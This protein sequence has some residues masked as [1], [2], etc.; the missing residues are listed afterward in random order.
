MNA[1]LVNTVAPIKCEVTTIRQPERQLC[2]WLGLATGAALVCSSLEI[3]LLEQLDSLSKYMTFREIAWDSA[4]AL[5]VLLGVTLLWWLFGL[6]LVV[7]ANVNSRK[8][9]DFY[10][11]FWHFA[12]ILPLS[13]F[14]LDLF[15]A[16]RLEFFPH[17]FPELTGWITLSL[18]FLVLA[19]VCIYTIDVPKIQRFC[20]HYVAPIGYMHFG[21]AAI[22]TVGLLGHNIHLYRDYIHSGRTVSAAN[23]PDVYLVTVDALRAED[24]SLYGYDRSTT[25]NLDRFAQRSFTFDAFFANSNFTTPA[26]TSIETGKLPWSHRVFHLGGFLRGEAQKENLAELLH[27]QG[28]Y[29]ATIS[30]NYLATPLLHRTLPSYDASEYHPPQNVFGVSIRYSN[31]LGLNTLHTFTGPLLTRLAGV[32]FY[33]ETLIWNQYYPSPSRPVFEDARAL[34]GREDISQP[35]FVWVHILPPHDP[36]LA[37]PPYKGRFLP[38]DKLTRA[39]NFLGL[40]N[41]TK[42]QSATTE[43]LRA[44][45]DEMILYAD[46]SVGEFL[47]WLD[48][49]GRADRSIIIISADHGESF[50]HNWFLHSG[51]HLFNGVIHIPLLIHLPGQKQGGRITYAAQQSDLLPTI[52]DLLGRP[53][54]PWTDG[55]SLKPLL[56][57]QTLP[58]RYIMSM[59]LEPNSEFDSI[60]KGTLAIMDDEYKYVLYLDS[61]VEV[62]Y[63]YRK[64][65]TEEHNLIDTEPEIAKQMRDALLSKLRHVNNEPLLPQ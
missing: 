30:S 39:Y 52:L 48:R 13:Y 4:L 27:Q 31:I 8:G 59:N 26:T 17:W 7:I 21:L 33:L 18:V 58:E 54:P 35:R 62:L 11:L 14:F 16:I 37:P 22:A 23:L 2:P 47:D 6:L 50:E 63:N 60:T 29:T 12:L 65:E 51:R 61:K 5:L 44:R 53:A 24:M 19:G 46:N 41:T 15:G 43:E 34:I 49:T 64:D 55:V 38:G 40:R 36:Y 57:G 3:E 28:Y 45:Y 20:R 56:E 9:R 10:S 32:R 25:P 42:P 1:T